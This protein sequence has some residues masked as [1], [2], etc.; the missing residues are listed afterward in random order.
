MPNAQEIAAEAVQ[1]LLYSQAITSAAATRVQTVLAEAL[2]EA[3]QLQ[4]GLPD[5]QTQIN[6]LNRRLTKL[7]MFQGPIAGESVQ[8]VEVEAAPGLTLTDNVIVPVIAHP[9]SADMV[10]G[11]VILL[12][13]GGL[14]R[15][16]DREEVVVERTVTE[17]VDGWWVATA[18]YG[19]LLFD[20]AYIDDTAEVVSIPHEVR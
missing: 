7:E 20:H 3:L 4:P 11:T 16:E 19:R 6:R 5:L 18:D 15:V 9:K 8:A 13:I 17:P 1:K 12:D 14:G 2:T 10:K